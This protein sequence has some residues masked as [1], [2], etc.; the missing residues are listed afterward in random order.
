MKVIVGC[1]VFGRVRDALIWRGHDAWSCDILPTRTPG[2]HIQGNILDHL[3]E[4][5]EMGIFFPPCTDLAVS[6]AR[7]FAEKRLDGRQQKSIEFFLNLYNAPIPKVGLENPV[8]IMSTVLRK[9]DQII[10]P[11]QFGH[12]ESKA[13]CLWLRGLPKLRPTNILVQRERWEN[14]TPSGQNKLGPSPDRAA[15]RGATYSG[16]AEAMA[17][18]WGIKST[19]D[20]KEGKMKCPNC[21]SELSSQYDTEAED[22][23]WHC[24]NC[25]G[26][27]AI[28][29]NTPTYPWTN[30]PIELDD[31]SHKRYERNK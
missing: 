5:W 9:P 18:Q 31:E 15:I 26:S 23:Y 1:E 8:G 11:W 24:F 29:G 7:Y 20:Q 2:P 12:P 4:G 28:D 22:Y 16:I 6:G 30:V 3:D 14:M 17:D 21:S 10:Q 25:E 19:T 27:F 13:T